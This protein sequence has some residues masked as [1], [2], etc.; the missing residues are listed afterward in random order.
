[1]RAVAG[2]ADVLRGRPRLAEV[3]TVGVVHVPLALSQRREESAI[4]E[5]DDVRLGI[6]RYA[7]RI[8]D[9]DWRFPRLPAIAR[10]RAGADGDLRVALALAVQAEDAGAV[11]KL[12]NGGGA[13]PLGEDRARLRVPRLAVVVAGN[14]LHARVLSV[15]AKGFPCEG[16]S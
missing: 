10:A 1:M 3:R 6:E 4:V 12:A 16:I 11:G 15:L 2:E 8:F 14:H 7:G 9:C 5:S 13:D